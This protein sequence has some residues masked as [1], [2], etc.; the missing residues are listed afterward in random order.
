MGHFNA[1]AL[2]VKLSIQLPLTA[3]H[4]WAIYSRQFLLTLLLVPSWASLSR[5]PQLKRASLLE[6]NCV[7]IRARQRKK[8]NVLKGVTERGNESEYDYGACDGGVGQ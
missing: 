3:V 5:L 2:Y 7:T 1:F 6:R 8:E 4:V